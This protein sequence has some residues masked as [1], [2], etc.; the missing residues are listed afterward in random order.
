MKGNLKSLIALAAIP[1][2]ITSCSDDVAPDIQPG[3]KCTVAVITQLPAALNSRF[4]E[5]TEAKHLQYAVYEHGKSIPLKIYGN[6]TQTVGVGSFAG[7]LTTTVELQLASN[8]S[9]DV[10]FWADATT[11]GT[12]SPYTFDATAQE[13]LVNYDLVNANDE[14]LDAFYAVETIDVT[15]NMTK[16][17]ELRRPFAQLNIGTDDLAASQSAGFA[18]ATTEVTVAAGNVLNLVSGE[19]TGVETRKFKVADIP[20]DETYPIAGY[21]YLSMNY[22]LTG[23]DKSLVDVTLTVNGTYTRTFSTVPVQRNY[24]TNIYGSLL[25]NAVDFNVVINPEFDGELNL[26]STSEDLA[27]Q[28]KTPGQ[29]IQVADNVQLEIPAEIAEGVTIAGGNS[30]VLAVPNGYEHPH[31]AVTFKNITLARDDSKSTGDGCYFKVNADNVV[32]D[33]V[34]LAI[35]NLQ[36]GDPETGDG[37]SYVGGGIYVFGGNTLTVKN[38]DM[39]VRAAYGVFAMDP[40]TTIILENCN[41]GSE[42]QY[43]VNQPGDG[44]LIAKNTTFRGWMS[45]WSEGELTEC[46]FVYGDLWDP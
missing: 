34:K 37:A 2:F 3:D 28:A 24:R 1:M 18:A 41:F 40:G 43:C 31:H 44:K 20:V 7:G 42:F 38:T 39:T 21:D 11:D 9:Y 27:D 13:I 26:V 35:I 4:G 22:L 14:A 17:V 29:Y 46:T 5:G 16:T 25:T 6:D 15:G 36:A 12:P 32:L 8:K 23:R 45:G 10:V 30:S 19:V 33:N